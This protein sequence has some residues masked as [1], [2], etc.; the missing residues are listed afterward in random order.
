S[1]LPRAPVVSAV[2]AASDG[3]VHRLGAIRI[4]VAALELGAGRRAK[5]D[6][7]DHAVGIVCHK[8][9]G[10]SVRAGDSLAEIHAARADDA[11][12]AVSAV[13]EAYELADTA[14]P[15]QPIV[16]DVLSS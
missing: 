13:L 8:K 10:D 16:L 6:A 15:A 5:E 14:P 2:P 11:E 9:R 3:F 12:A 7:I 4:G 1:S